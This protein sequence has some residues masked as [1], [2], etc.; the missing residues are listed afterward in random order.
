MMMMMNTSGGGDVDGDDEYG[1]EEG[2]LIM[3]MNAD[4]ASTSEAK[5]GTEPHSQKSVAPWGLLA[6]AR[7]L[8][9]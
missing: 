7:G 8:L 6:S 2:M 4:D 9:P 1:Y 5:P 3:M